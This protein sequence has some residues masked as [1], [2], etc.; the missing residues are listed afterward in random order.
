MSSLSVILAGIGFWLF[1]EGAIYAIA[2][3]FMKQIMR[4]VSE[5]APNEIMAT[6]LI[7]SAIGFGCLYAA[8]NW[9]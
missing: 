9:L 5:M 7:S 6:G 1:L 4:Q 8:F 2:P 3:S